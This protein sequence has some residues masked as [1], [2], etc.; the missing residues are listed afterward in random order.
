MGGYKQKKETTQMK[1]IHVIMA[2]A[3][4][5]IQPTIAAVIVAVM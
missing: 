1:R 5:M 4:G 3:I 2:L